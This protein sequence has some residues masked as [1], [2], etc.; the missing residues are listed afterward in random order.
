MENGVVSVRISEAPFLGGLERCKT[1][2][3]GKAFCYARRLPFFW[4][5]MSQHS[6]LSLLQ[7]SL[8]LLLRR[9]LTNS[10]LWEEAPPIHT[11]SLHFGYLLHVSNLL[12]SS[13]SCN[14]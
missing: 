1:N 8:Y 2:F 14:S 9:F 6:L 7:S 12:Y 5:Q 10:Y 13:V 3:V 11:A 4:T